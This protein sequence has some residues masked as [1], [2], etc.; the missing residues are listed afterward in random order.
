MTRYFHKIASN[1]D[2]TEKVHVVHPL[3]FKI[4]TES[5]HKNDKNDSKNLAFGLLKNYLPYPV[6]IKSEESRQLQILLNLRRRMVSTRTK[7]IQQTKSIIRS[8]GIKTEA[9]SLKS[10]RGFLEIINLLEKEEF[11]KET[12]EF[13]FEEFKI[14][15][16]KIKMIEEKIMEKIKQNF[17]KEYKLL[18]SIPGIAFVT[19]ATIIAHVDG[20][21][22]FKK[23]SQLSAYFGLVPSEYS[24]GEKIKHG[25][26]T[27]EGIKEVRALLIQAAWTLIRIRSKNDE[28]L[29]ALKKKYYKLAFK[30]KNSQKAIVAIARHLSRIIFGVLNNGMPYCCCFGGCNPI[31]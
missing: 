27:K 18:I 3:K 1:L 13:L 14:E 6:H 26:I 17:I 23:E 7:L 9:K 16:E 20:I 12:I 29:T 8:L 10:T 28:R 24:S 31:L 30:G 22:R 11:D 4:I 15:D 2:N 5:K 19:A 21:K 25:R